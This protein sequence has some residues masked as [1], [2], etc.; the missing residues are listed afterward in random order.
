MLRGALRSLLYREEPS[1]NDLRFCHNDSVVDM[2]SGIVT[3]VLFVAP[4]KLTVSYCTESQPVSSALANALTPHALAVRYCMEPNP[5]YGT[6]QDRGKVQQGRD[7][8]FHRHAPYTNSKQLRRVAT[9]TIALS[10]AL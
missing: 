1:Q 4:H 8:G 9:V 5:V 2:C 10:I 3:S 6:W 7:V